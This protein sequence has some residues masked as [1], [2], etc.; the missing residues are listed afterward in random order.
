MRLGQR[1][2]MEVWL[3]DFEFSTTSGEIP[4][5]V[6]MVA[7]EFAT[8]RKIRLWQDE[9]RNT[10]CPP[11]AIDSD[12]LFVAYFA[13]TEVGCHLALGWQLPANVLDLYT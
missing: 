13:S 3:V 5:P 9:L 4:V 2:F 12:S 7:L 10:K 1:D 6:C 8:K 11:Y